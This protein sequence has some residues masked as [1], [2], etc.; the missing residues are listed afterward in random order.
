[1]LN[2]FHMMVLAVLASQ[3]GIALLLMVMAMLEPE[4]SGA[5]A[6]PTQGRSRA[7]LTGGRGRRS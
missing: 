2:D 1:M 6:R 7:F 3:G 4:K 5:G